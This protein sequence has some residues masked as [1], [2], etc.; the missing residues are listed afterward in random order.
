MKLIISFGLIFIFQSVLY[1]FWISCW[2]SIIFVLEKCWKCLV[3]SSLD[4]SNMYFTSS[5]N[6]CYIKALLT[7]QFNFRNLT[8]VFVD[9]GSCDCGSVQSTH[10]VQLYTERL[11]FSIYVIEHVYY[12]SRLQQL[13]DFSETVIQRNVPQKISPK[14]QLP[15][16]FKALEDYL[17]LTS[18]CKNSMSKT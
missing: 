2:P 1:I 15:F 4:S 18:G 13:W 14:S 9:S 10:G 11:Q 17:N 12:I 5:W 7:N 8:S 6:F 16:S 3:S